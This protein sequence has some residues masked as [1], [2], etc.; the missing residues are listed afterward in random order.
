MKTVKEILDQKKSDI[1]NASQQLEL[2][3]DDALI[4]ETEYYTSKAAMKARLSVV[5]EIAA[6]MKVNGYI[7]DDDIIRAQLIGE[8]GNIR[9]FM[10]K[11]HDVYIETAGVV[12]E[13]LTDPRL[14]EVE[15]WKEILGI[16]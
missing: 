11:S 3:F 8:N 13:T 12:T 1:N 4:G 7:K 10:T 16:E 14:S 15:H 6:D 9:M 2:A 5:N